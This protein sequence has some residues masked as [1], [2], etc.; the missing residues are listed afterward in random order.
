MVTLGPFSEMYSKFQ[1]L[2]LGTLYLR[3]ET[4]LECIIR[5][6]CSYL[7]HK[8]KL[9][10]LLCLGDFMTCSARFNIQSEGSISQLW[11]TVGR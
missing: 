3:F 11:S 1:F 4:C 7:R 2:G 5:H 10:I 6:I 8:Q 9:V